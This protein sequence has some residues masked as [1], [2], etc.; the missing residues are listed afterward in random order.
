MIKVVLLIC[1][2][3]ISPADCKERNAR[4]V[5]QGPDARNEMACAMR[6]QAYL[7]STALEIDDTEYLKVKC[8]RTD[9]GLDNVG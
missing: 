1:A 8:V 5:L 2:M 9:I 7:A 6:S 3:S 4:V